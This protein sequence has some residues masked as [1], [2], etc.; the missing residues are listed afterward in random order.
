MIMKWPK[1]LTKSFCSLSTDNIHGE[2]QGLLHAV[3][4]SLVVVG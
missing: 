2:P 3:R 1:L 4:L